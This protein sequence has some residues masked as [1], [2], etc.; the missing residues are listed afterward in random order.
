MPDCSGPRLAAGALAL[1]RIPSMSAVT[2][3]LIGWNVGVWLYL[4]LIAA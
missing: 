4:P 3:T 1:Q 2:R